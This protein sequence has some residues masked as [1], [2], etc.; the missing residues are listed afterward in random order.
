MKNKKNKP[1]KLRLG[2]ALSGF[3]IAIRQ[4]NSFRFQMIAAISALVFLA[5]MQPEPIWWA[6]IVIMIT[7]V[8]TAE[9]FNTA[10]EELC[11]YVQPEHHDAIGKIKDVAAAAVL[12]ASA[13]SL[14]VAALMIVDL[15]L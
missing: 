7:A 5:V 3:I 4:E 10:L 12:M 11:D 15:L 6:I 13:G 2:F 8:L 9:L 14:F 1:F